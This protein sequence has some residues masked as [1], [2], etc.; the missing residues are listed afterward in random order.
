MEEH[1]FAYSPRQT[2]VAHALHASHQG[3]DQVSGFSAL[4][5]HHAP[6]SS[7]EGAIA[8]AVTDITCPHCGESFPLTDAIRRQIEASVR[9][10]ERAAHT[11]EVEAARAEAAAS[12]AKRTAERYEL[13][14]VEAR[15][16]AAEQKTT[17]A[18]QRDQLREQLKEMRSLRDEREK[19]KLANERAIQEQ[20]NTVRTEE[21]ARAVEET[22]LKHAETEKQLH[23]ARAQVVRLKAQLEQGSQQTQ[24]EVLELQVEDQLRRLFP[25]DEITEVKKG[26]RGA[27]VTQVVKTP[28]GVT[29]GI[30]L[31][32]AKNAQWQ[33]SWHAK[34]RADMREAGADHAVLISANM[35]DTMESV[36][37]LDGTEWAARPAAVGALAIMLRQSV[38]Y[39]HGV[40]RL[41]ESSDEKVRVLLAYVTGPEF[42][43][44]LDSMLDASTGVQQEQEHQKR[45]MTQS[46]A[47]QDKALRCLTDSVMGLSGDLAGLA[48]LPPADD[49]E[50]DDDDS[51]K[52]LSLLGN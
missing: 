17:I 12:A 45:V 51:G 48:G 40:T 5:R 10:E 52:W 16:E 39:A 28:L 38:L 36:T 34:L 7:E 26:Q 41:H 27:D 25:Q 30:I 19:E 9:E 4:G 32:E 35:P 33:G 2:A 31:W 8:A 50:D 37:H 13:Q 23:D 15:D 42:R 43:H 46:W 20:I 29:A 6:Q 18:E 1:P 21:R 44:R 3:I 49:D 47:K 24:G 14:L 11:T 22:Q